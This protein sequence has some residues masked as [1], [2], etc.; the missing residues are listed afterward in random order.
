VKPRSR[1]HRQAVTGPT[2]TPQRSRTDR[3][4]FGPVHSPPSGGCFRRAADRA[5]RC[6][7]E[8]FGSDPFPVRPSVSPSGPRAF[9][10]WGTARTVTPDS[11]T[12]A[13]TW[14][15][16]RGSSARARSQTA[17]QRVRSTG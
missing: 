3:A 16:V 9:H 8:G 5:S 2:A 7:S 15:G 12:T 13:A 10:R 11:P 4:T 14:A 1:S 6:R 17:C